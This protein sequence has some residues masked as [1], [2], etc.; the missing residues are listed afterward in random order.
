[1]KEV[2]NIANYEAFY[3]DYLEGNLSEELTVA[4][5]AFLAEHP[6]LEVDQELLFL[7]EE[8]LSMDSFEKELLKK[9]HS[10]VSETNL[11]VLLIARQEG[12]LT[13]KEEQELNDFLSRHPEYR[14]DVALYAQVKLTPET[15]LV[16]DK[17]PLY[18]KEIALF[19]A[20]WMVRIASV[21]ALLILGIVIFRN[22][23]TTHPGNHPD[24][25]K[26]HNK[27]DKKETPVPDPAS[28]VAE[29]QKTPVENNSDQVKQVSTHPSDLS[30]KKQA[31]QNPKQQPVEPQSQPETPEERH[32]PYHPSILPELKNQK[33]LAVTPQVDQQTNEKTS[34]D[35]AMAVK[36]EEKGYTPIE[37]LKNKLEEK[38]DGQL[39]FK[40]NK[41]GEGKK[42]F[43][44]KIGKFEVSRNG[45]K[46]K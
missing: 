16:M 4:L 15:D 17:E 43:S 20:T 12:N 2:I 30:A 34:Q 24:S 11:E 22:T 41:A 33:V 19:S 3:L 28:M 18:R 42:G 45:R 46:G 9:N 8:S 21:A 32:Q 36:S 31:N 7:E 10:P 26:A 13:A 27:P 44:L 5:E 1:M 38:I 35:M 14:K 39:S 29:N 6:E 37:F 25:M 40:S 23:V